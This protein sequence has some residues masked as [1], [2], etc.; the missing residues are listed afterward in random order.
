VH[1]DVWPPRVPVAEYGSVPPS[2]TWILGPTQRHPPTSH[3]DWFSCSYGTH[4]CNQQSDT[5]TTLHPHAWRRPHLC[6]AC[7]RCGL[8]RLR[9]WQSRS[10]ICRS[11]IFSVADHTQSRTCRPRNDAVC[12]R[13][14][15]P[16]TSA[17]EASKIWKGAQKA[18]TGAREGAGWGGC[19]PPRG[20]V[21]QN[22]PFRCV[23]VRKCAPQRPML[24]AVWQSWSLW[25]GYNSVLYNKTIR[26]D[27]R[28]HF[29]VRSK[30][31]MSQLNL[32]HGNNN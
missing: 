3:L 7:M 29:N 5:Q 25:L 9:A 4:G 30:A 6:T 16:F 28:R 18:W 1:I 31:D 27:T 21:G 12:Q 11:C 2:N 15:W 22:P 26:Y 10:S 24:I 23:Y 17:G 14:A 32:P 8:T 20:F 19:L 13:L